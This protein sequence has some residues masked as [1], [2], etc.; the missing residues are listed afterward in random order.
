MFWKKVN[1]CALALLVAVLMVVGGGLAFQILAS[2]E[3]PAKTADRPSGDAVRSDQPPGKKD[4]TMRDAAM[5]KAAQFV[6]EFRWKQYQN[7]NDAP[8]DFVPQ[9]SIHV[10]KAQLRLSEKKADKVAA[11]EAHLERI[12][13]IEEI[14]KKRFDASVAVIEYHQVVYYRLETE[15]WLEEARAA[16]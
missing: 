16:K 1:F 7:R 3:R 5:L 2:Q 11:Y 13:M 10:L 8:T 4:T 15:I 14:A 12:K 6:F 9:W